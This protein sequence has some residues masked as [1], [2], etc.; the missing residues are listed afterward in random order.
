MSYFTLDTDNNDINTNNRPMSEA[1]DK[2]NPRFSGHCHSD[3]AKKAISESQSK[4]YEMIRKLVRM[5]MT[6]PLTEERVRE[7]CANIIDDY[8]KRNAFIVKPNN[9][10]NKKPIDINL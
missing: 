4:R 8:C 1:S 9:N 10:S 3:Q 6:Q 2:I 5:G 7:I